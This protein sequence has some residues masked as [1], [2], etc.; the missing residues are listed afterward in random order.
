LKGSS[1]TNQDL[2]AE[3]SVLN[4]RIQELELSDS[5]RKRAEEAQHE[6]EERYLHLYEHAPFGIGMATLDGKILAANRMMQIITGFSDEELKAINLADLY[7]NPDYRA[8]L[9]EALKTSGDVVD[10]PALFKRKD[11]TEYNVSLTIGMVNIAGK[12]VVQTLVQDITRRKRMEEALQESEKA[13]RQLAQENEL[14]AEIGRHVR[15][16]RK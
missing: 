8:Q 12:N 10:Y 1:K 16:H 13:A 7:V 5:E 4:K 6:S 9:L 14:V 15:G 3:I 11:G 2:V